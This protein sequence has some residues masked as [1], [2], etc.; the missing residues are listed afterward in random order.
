MSSLS[1]LIKLWPNVHEF[2]FL[3]L[4][5]NG[6]VKNFRCYSNL[7][8]RTTQMEV[9]LLRLHNLITLSIIYVSQKSGQRC[10]YKGTVIMSTAVKSIYIMYTQ[11]HMLRY[12]R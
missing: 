6:Q 9:L 10:G 8:I 7:H 1:H 4:S 12:Q 3:A 2:C 5:F 11:V